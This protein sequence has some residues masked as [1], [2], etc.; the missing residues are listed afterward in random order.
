MA[1][2]SKYIRIGQM[3]L[4]VC[5]IL[6]CSSP[7]NKQKYMEAAKQESVNS[8]KTDSVDQ[9]KGSEKAYE[10][11]KD[12]LSASS[13]RAFE[14]RAIQKLQD[15]AGY[16]QI[17]SDLS[18]DKSFRMQARQMMQGIFSDGNNT[19]STKTFDG[20]N[21]LKLTVNQFIDSVSNQYPKLKVEIYDIQT[22]QNLHLTNNHVYAGALTFWQTTYRVQKTGNI[23]LNEEQMLADITL[24]RVDK[25]FGNTAKE[26]WEAFLGNIEI[27][28][29]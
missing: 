4:P 28:K 3:M 15:I 17:L 13:L 6:S 24:K 12:T 14:L 8:I 27:L 25:E 2:L 21:S 5:I 23:K 19:I 16:V 1:G 9:Q 18:L 22:I 20:G 26:V 29:K 10:F 7:V 11:E